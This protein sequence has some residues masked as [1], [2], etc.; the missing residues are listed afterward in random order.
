MHDTEKVPAM[1]LFFIFLLFFFVI[2]FIAD[3]RG[4]YIPAFYTAGSLQIFAVGI[5]FLSHCGK[6]SY[7]QTT[8]IVVRRTKNYSLSKEWHSSKGELVLLTYMQKCFNILLLN[9]KPSQPTQTLLHCGYGNHIIQFIIKIT[10]SS[11]VIGFKNSYFTLIHL[12][13]CYRIVCHQ[14]ACYRTVP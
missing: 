14:T 9:F 4:S 11:I 6:N 7:F 1:N 13:S 8:Q 5:L 12:P 3:L 2:G 10:I